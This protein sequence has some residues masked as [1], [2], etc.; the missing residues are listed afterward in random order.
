MGSLR[1]K[2][3]STS[4]DQD[5]LRGFFTDAKIGEKLY[6]IAFAL[7][8]LA[9]S[10][11]STTFD[12]WLILVK[13]A[14]YAP[15]SLLALKMIVVDRY[16]IDEFFFIVMMLCLGGIVTLKSGM[17]NPFFWCLF[18]FTAKGVRFDSILKVFA[19]SSAIVVGFA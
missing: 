13:I 4:N 15:L 12:R 18:T 11:D 10:S 6:L 5:I 7:H 14:K 1:R 9:V 17:V 2:P 19:V 3:L 8:I 16:R